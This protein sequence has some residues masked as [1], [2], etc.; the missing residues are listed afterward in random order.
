MKFVDITFYWNDDPLKTPKNCVCAIGEYD[1]NNP[2]HQEW[3]D[4]I[5]YW[6]DSEK[7]IVGDEFTVISYK[8]IRDYL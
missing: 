4:D 1:E 8:N 5:F 6:F 3:D 7:D 2:M